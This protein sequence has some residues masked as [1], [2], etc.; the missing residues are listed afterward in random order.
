MKKLFVIGFAMLL[1]MSA[2]A[3]NIVGSPH[4]F[5]AAG[6]NST[7]EICIT[8]HTPHNAPY[9]TDAD[10]SQVPLWNHDVTTT[11]FTMYSSSTLNGTIDADVSGVSRLC[12]SCHDSTISLDSFGTVTGNSGTNI[13]GT[14]LV[15]TDLSDDHP[16]SITYDSTNDTGLFDE[17]TTTSGLGDTISADMLFSGKV[18]CAS[19][20]DVHDGAGLGAGGYLLVKQNSASALCLTCHDK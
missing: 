18:E 7:G 13:S 17:S 2:M 4:D 16:V 10:G 14:A 20:Y 3:Q 19:C 1:G 11:T 15:G 12:L 5:S 6:W 8:C 9:A